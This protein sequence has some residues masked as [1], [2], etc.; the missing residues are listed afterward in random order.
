MRFAAHRRQEG[1]YRAMLRLC[2]FASLLLENVDLRGEASPVPQRLAYR[3][4]ETAYLT[5]VSESHGVYVD[6]V[7]GSETIR[8]FSSVGRCIPL[9]CTALGRVLLAG[10]ASHR[11]KRGAGESIGHLRQP[12]LH[13]KHSPGRSVAIT[14]VDLDERS[15]MRGGSRGT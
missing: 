6:N 8:V 12:P 1:T 4:G 11:T 13:G 15:Q 5:A 10:T 3:T 2:E 14:G 7:D 9:R